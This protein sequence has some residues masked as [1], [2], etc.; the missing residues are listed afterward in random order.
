ML[1]PCV[2]GKTTKLLPCYAKEGEC[3][4]RCD[5]VL[6]CFKHTCEKTCHWGFCGFCTQTAVKTC[7]CEK[8]KRGVLC[9]LDATWKYSCSQTC[10]KQFKCGNH[11]CTAVCH[12]GPCAECEQFP[13]DGKTCPCGKLQIDQRTSCSDPLPVCTATCGKRLI[14]GHTCASKCHLGP[15]T[16]G[17]PCT[18]QAATK[19]TWSTIDCLEMNGRQHYHVER[20]TDGYSHW[21]SNYTA[22]S[23]VE[24]LHPSRNSAN[25]LYFLE[26]LK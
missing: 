25:Y 21:R 17:P 7:Y 19:C 11:K 16:A 2:C 4:L 18:K 15:C 13:G 1:R 14:C 8:A 26:S 6:N 3:D 5:K 9:T 20:C 23:R 24:Y 22:T 10:D 12:A